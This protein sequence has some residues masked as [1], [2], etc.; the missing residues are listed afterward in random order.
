MTGEMAVLLSPN[1]VF[2]YKRVFFN[3]KTIKRHLS[4]KDWHTIKNVVEK[5]NLDS[6]AYFEAPSGERGIDGAAYASFEIC[7]EDS[8]Y[9]SQYYDG[10]NPHKKLK[11]LD[12]IVYEIYNSYDR[13]SWEKLNK[14]SKKQEK[15][16][17]EENNKD[18]I[19]TIVEVQ[20]KFNGGEQA[21][22]N[23]LEN[24]P[25]KALKNGK[26][27]GKVFIQFTVKKNGTVSDAKIICGVNKKI[28]KAAIEII[29][30][31]PKWESDKQRGKPVNVRMVLPIVFKLEN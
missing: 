13:I 14:L 27:E 19:Y 2:I 9:S 4:K 22:L 16:R 10:G 7:F 26:G 29:E 18:M 25:K 24:R 12:S 20:P 15:K 5:V 8:L 3:E 6:L 23:F 1:Q 31:M 21:L 17:E 30:S 28:D 11:D